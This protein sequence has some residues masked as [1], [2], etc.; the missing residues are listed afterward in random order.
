MASFN[1]IQ[2]RERGLQQH[3]T[4]AQMVMI[5]I[6]G[7]VGTGL[8]MG[9]AFAIGF[10]GPVGLNALLGGTSYCPPVRKST[11]PLLYLPITWSATPQAAHSW[12]EISV[13]PTCLPLL[14]TETLL[15]ML[16]QPARMPTVSLAASGLILMDV[17]VTEAE[18]YCSSSFLASR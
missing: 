11:T 3:L 13:L 2:Q 16:S 9:S 4:S 15:L 12:I 1:D 14:S 6:G 18:S 10:A 17:M 7:A 5:A 8:F